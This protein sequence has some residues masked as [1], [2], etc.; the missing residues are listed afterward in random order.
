MKTTKQI[1][2]TALTC[3]AILCVLTPSAILAQGKTDSSFEYTTTTE[4]PEPPKTSAEKLQNL[5]K[6]QDKAFSDL[7]AMLNKLP[8]EPDLL[9]SKDLFASIDQSDR[10]MKKIRSACSTLSSALRSE[11]KTIKESSSFSDEQRLELL[12]SAKT[13]ADNCAVLSGNVDHAIQRLAAAYKVIP[14]WKTIHHS[15]RN[16]QG[17]GKAS[18]QVK[19]QVESYLKSFTPDPEAKAESDNGEK[20]S[21]TSV[22]STGD[23]FEK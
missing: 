20:A 1:A 8:S 13:L 14:K 7:S 22:K 9:G 15:Y 17:D 11:A 12:S 2:I 23:A 19:A 16:L 5:Q 4:K 10:E 18:E 21:A 3:S 6:S